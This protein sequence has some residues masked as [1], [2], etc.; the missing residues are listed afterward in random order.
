VVDIEGTGGNIY[1]S[2]IMDIAVLVYDDETGEVVDSFATVVN[3]GK[4]PDAYVRKMTGITPKMLKRAP[5]FHEIAK[6]I[7]QMTEGTVLTAHNAS[8]D[9]GIL[10]QEFARL[11]YDFRRPVLDTVELAARLLPDLKGHG[12]DTLIE[13]LKIPVSGRHR[14]LGDA[15]ATV[16]VLKVLLQKDPA[17]EVTRSLIRQPSDESSDRPAK[18]WKLIDRIPHKSGILSLYD[19]HGRLLYSGYHPDMRVQMEKIFARQAGKYRHLRRHVARASAEEMASPFIGRLQA[20]LM[21]KNIGWRLHPRF[22][23]AESLTLPVQNGLLID[24]KGRKPGEKAVILVENGKP[25]GY[26]FVNLDWQAGDRESLR[27][28][29][30][31][32]PEDCP[33][34]QWLAARYAAKNY[35]DQIIPRE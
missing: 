22:A 24:R 11:G 6:R 18:E 1:R 12:L 13:A 19:R 28:R 2:R 21:R 8:F 3:P 33:Y 9:Y 30:T 25:A 31:P 17:R 35:F 29:M 23:E 10:K 34:T 26:A 5:A 15:R 14:A 27:R 16:E 4:K 20:A 32:I 7:V